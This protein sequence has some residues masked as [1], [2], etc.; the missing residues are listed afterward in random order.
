MPK[1]WTASL[2]PLQ[3]A[4]KEE[5]P[6]WLS[7][8]QNPG[9]EEPNAQPDA[10][11][12]DEFAGM[13]KLKGLEPAAM[14]DEDEKPNKVPAFS[15]L[16][17]AALID[18]QVPDWLRDIGPATGTLAEGSAQEQ[19]KAWTDELKQAGMQPTELPSTDELQKQAASEKVQ[20][21]I[22]PAPH[23]EL[24]SMEEIADSAEE[25]DESLSWL[26]NL[27][28]KE[29]ADEEELLT[30]PED[31][32]QAKPD[33]APQDEPPEEESGALAWL[34]GVEAQAESAKEP[35]GTKSVQANEDLETMDELSQ[36]LAMDAEAA[37]AATVPG[38]DERLAA[39]EAAVSAETE[40]SPAKVERTAPLWLRELSA[41]V[42][43]G[44][45]NAAEPRPLEDAPDWLDEL[46]VEESSIP[47][48]SP[49]EEPDQ[50][51]EPQEGTDLSKLDWLEE[52]GPPAAE[53][54][55]G[56]WVPE[57]ELSQEEKFKPASDSASFISGGSRTISL[58]EE[59]IHEASV[60][61]RLDLARKEMTQG[62][63]ET[64]MRHYSGLLRRREKLED[65]VAD[66]KAA[67]RRNEKD[68]SL[69]QALGDAHMR[70]NQLR[71]ALDC[72]TKAEDLL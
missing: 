36:D 25:G 57:A 68:A 34:D 33:W 19:N 41:E 37:D 11:I 9:P 55:K 4:D 8:E 51:P 67:V 64:A 27:A 14:P 40:G 12:G 72:Y 69:W 15:K 43:E 31:R 35:G 26:E 3:E 71:E 65:V 1:A 60:T 32:R 48:E 17:T 2:Q 18:D 54:Q 39:S 49:Q 10:E 63:K 70:N 45:K 61:D 24:A 5:L 29:G 59:D 38:L 66:L 22:E 58:S 53:P 50:E 56:A 16:P 52:M 20:A 23:D 47:V 30:T 44:T 7:I 28:A 21:S 46:R 6:D 13:E 42:E 62:N